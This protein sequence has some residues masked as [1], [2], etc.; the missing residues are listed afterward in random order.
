MSLV[1]LA[2]CAST[3]KARH[4]HD[5]DQDF[6]GYQTF[7]WISE[8]PMKLAENTPLLNPLLEPLIMAEVESAL[9]AKGYTLNND[10]A[11]ADF[12][13]SFTVGTRE[14][15]RVNTYHTM[16]GGVGGYP[17]H[18]RWGSAYYYGTETFVS[19]YEEGMLAVDVFDT[20]ERKPVWHGVATKSIENADRDDLAATVKAAVDAVLSGFPPG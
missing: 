3:F 19:H 7:A 15:I 16:G 8:K 5:P 14:Q 17:S 9:G 10:P 20:K 11:A 1:L 13:L 2:G 18:W 6:T 4:D 12:V